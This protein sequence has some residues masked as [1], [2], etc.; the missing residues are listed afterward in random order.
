[1]KL[2]G[3]TI[4]ITGGG[5][6][7][8]RALAEA[9]HNL[10][11]KVIISGRR[12]E[13]LEEVLSA[14]PGMSAVELD[15]QDLSSIE[16]TAEQLIKDFPDLNV[17]VNNAGIMLFDE[18]AGVI[19]E[20]VLV[21]TVST[22]LLGPIRMT[23][24]LI[25]HLKSKEEAV[26]INTTSSIGFIPYAATAVYSAT[27]AALHSYTLSQRYLLKNT[28]V[29]VLEIIPPGVQTEL[30][31][32]LSDDPHAMPLEAFIKETIRLLGTDAEEVLVEQA[33]MIRDN[34]GPNEG[35]FVTQLNDMASQAAKGH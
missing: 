24:S 10:G 8:G 9:L 22:N 31:A 34:Q 28:T 20:E 35:A 26:I 12:K 2:T 6:G 5:S 27:K 23:S 21:S 25:E 4:F 11:N 18:A 15:I 7:I 1:M 32:D 13:R 33:K 3:N 29:K 30:M 17:L 19:N 14:N 16:V